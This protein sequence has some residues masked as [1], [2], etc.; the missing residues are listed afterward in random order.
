MPRLFALDQ[1]FPDPIV[2]VL[3]DFQT[4]AELVPLRQIDARLTQDMDDW[5]ILLALY[6]HERAWDGLITTDTGMLDLARELCVLIQTRLT[7]VAI[8]AAG[9][10]P[11]KASGLL[12]AYLPGVC[13]RT[14]PGKPQIWMPA[15]AERAGI[16]P[17]GR[18]T[19]VAEHRHEDTKKLFRAE[20]LTDDG[21]AHD[22]L[23]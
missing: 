7:L 6:H 13:R 1:N 20:K 19:R 18:L 16:E 11:V 9:H 2:R 10:D 22:P 17:W 3:S 14:D 12:F 15:A 5:E 23:A 4:D 21:L 8:V